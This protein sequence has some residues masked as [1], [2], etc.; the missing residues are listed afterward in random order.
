MDGF[1]TCT[2]RTRIPIAAINA[3]IWWIKG[4]KVII[5]N[6]P[7]GAGEVLGDVRLG[8]SRCREREAARNQEQSS[9]AQRHICDHRRPERC[10]WI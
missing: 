8:K 6:E 3:A 10:S 9:A 1:L 7:R 5:D 2:A 4:T